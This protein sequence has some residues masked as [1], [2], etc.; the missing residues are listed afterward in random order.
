MPFNP[1]TILTALLIM[2]STLSRRAFSLVRGRPY[3]SATAGL[4]FLSSS[5][6]ISAQSSTV[7]EEKLFKG[8]ATVLKSAMRSYST[9]TCDPAL[10]V[11]PNPLLNK[12]HVPLFEDIKTEDVLPAVQEDLNAMKASFDG[13]LHTI[14]PYFSWLSY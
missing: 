10:D 14:F 13:E 8:S 12:K 2:W 6:Y 5:S 7:P 11:R 3:V 4:T 1:N 9:A